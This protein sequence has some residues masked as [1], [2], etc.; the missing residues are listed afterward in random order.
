MNNISINNLYLNSSKFIFII[1]LPITFFIW[2]WMLYGF[3]GGIFS[4]LLVYSLLFTI[5]FL[6]YQKNDLNSKLFFCFLSYCL[7]YIFSYYVFFGD[8]YDING[9]S[10]FYFHITS[11]VLYFISYL[12]GR[13]FKEIKELYLVLIFI[14]MV[15]IVF[16]NIDI[17]TFS[18]NLS[19]ANE[20][21]KG[22]YLG[23][24]DLFSLYSMILIGSLKKEQNKIYIF[25]IAV[26]ALFVLNSRSSLYIFIFSNLI[27]FMF[28]IKFRKNILLLLLSFSLFFL[29]LEQ[30]FKLVSENSR[31]FSILFGD[32]DQSSLE[33]KV[34]FK[35]GV[36]QILDNIF[37]G[38][39][40]GVINLHGSLGS[41]IHNLL[42]YWQ[43]YGLFAFL[44]SCYF[45]LFQSLEAILKFFKNKMKGNYDYIFILS[46]YLIV[47]VIFS[48]SYNWY[49]SWFILGLIHNYFNL[50]RKIL[51]YPEK[52]L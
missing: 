52:E 48:R 44:L 16:L 42:S 50:N 34:L 3:S 15:L 47:T 12:V 25:L 35:H 20:D 33:R 46:I 19:F 22:I 8:S 30:F 2:Y 13:N 24:S 21:L 40:G 51:I 7:I 29:Y 32:E 10:L 23:L 37:L 1:Y 31:M 45:F 4:V 27:Y 6:K 28:F 9:N 49:F 38:D 11:V 36:K 17:S 14:L 5:L 18:I 26:I 41:Y 39:Y 43:A